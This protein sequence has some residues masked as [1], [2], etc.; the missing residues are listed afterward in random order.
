[1]AVAG[2]LEYLRDSFEKESREVTGECPAV[3]VE[4][5]GRAL[6][7]EARAKGKEREQKISQALEEAIKSCYTCCYVADQQQNLL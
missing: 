6:E 7:K 4:D 2:H 3:Q 5:R 1:M